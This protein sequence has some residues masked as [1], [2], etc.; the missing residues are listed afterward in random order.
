MRY[1]TTD[2]W[3]AS[4]ITEEA[5]QFFYERWSELLDEAVSVTYRTPVA[6]TRAII[7]ELRH[8]LQQSKSASLGKESLKAIEQEAFGVSVPPYG[9][10][11]GTVTN[12]PVA[13]DVAGFAIEQRRAHQKHFL[14]GGAPD[15]IASSRDLVVLD[16]VLRTLDEH[17]TAKIIEA[18][19][20]II[21]DDQTGF[22]TKIRLI[23]ELTTAL[24][25]D[26][27]GRGF[28]DSFLRVHRRVLEQSVTEP[29]NE[30][31]RLSRFLA[32]LERPDEKVTVVLKVQGASAFWDRWPQDVIPAN[33]EHVWPANPRV[34]GDEQ[35][36]LNTSEGSRFVSL[37]YRSP[38][39]HSASRK[40]LSR[41]EQ[42]A[43]FAIG[44]L[45]LTFPTVLYVATQRRSDPT[46]ISVVDADRIPRAVLRPSQ[47]PTRVPSVNLGSLMSANVESTTL[48]RIAGA[49]R[50]YTIACQ[51][52]RPESG[53]TN[54]WTALEVLAHPDYGGSTI[55]RVVR[56][57]TPLLSAT[58]IGDWIDDLLGNLLA[59]R[60]EKLPAFREQLA[61]TLDE[62]GRI[63]PPLLLGAMSSEEKATA[64]FDLIESSPLLRKRIRDLHSL[65][66]TGTRL[67]NRVY[68]SSRRMEWQL[69]RIYR[70]RN[71]IAHGAELVYNADPLLQHLRLYV[72]SVM[73]SLSQIL[74]ADHSI[75][76]LED[77]TAAADSAFHNSLEWV[78]ST[79]SIREAGP[80]C[81][82]RLYEPA[83]QPFL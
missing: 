10:V 69:R 47:R 2:E 11:Q 70:A 3:A 56:S 60:I 28:A 42:V 39:H 16:E 1:R 25:P 21:F 7:R 45:P 13:A 73:Q 8:H 40:A 9:T 58:K 32:R 68:R 50:Y 78:R 24:V 74:Q 26:L 15:I 35:G 36:F 38:D 75:S 79:D 17:Y 76:T 64:L 30:R 34:A 80:D 31:E 12:D 19:G 57:V 29:R 48:R 23:D 27:L 67:G 44:G 14:T 20:G 46:L 71:D 81:W 41:F 53:F 72:Y 83:Y 37:E 82:T 63:A 49:L 4:E 18:L 65:F 54:L 61:E 55:E 22:G 33:H 77:A 59:A 51:Q 52:D 62:N 66:S 5:L 43:D 6:G